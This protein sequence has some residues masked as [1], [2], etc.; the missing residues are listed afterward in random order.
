MCAVLR[1][2][3]KEIVSHVNPE[4]LLVQLV[5][6]NLVTEDEHYMLMNQTFSPQ[7][8]NQLLIIA[9]FSKDPNT[10]VQSFYECLKA[11]KHHSGHQYLAD[12][13]GPDI[14]E[15]ENQHQAANNRGP[16]DSNAAATTTTVA[17]AAAAAAATTTT[18]TTTTATAAAAAMTESEIDRLL[19][20]LKSYWLQVAE[21][22]SAPQEMVNNATSSSQDPEEQ[23]RMFLQLYTMY[24]R[25]ENIYCALDELGI[26][27]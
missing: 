12:L 14:R 13:L 17:A 10:S 18:A 21:T 22:L 20:T 24:S 26:M 19:P 5:T 23:A 15:F 6:H 3:Y 2:H 16:S 27:I 1:K 25:K 4:E 9:L 7:K 11:E 8:R